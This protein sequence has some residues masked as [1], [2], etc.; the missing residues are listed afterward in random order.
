MGVG[1]SCYVL[2]CAKSDFRLVGAFFG[3]GIM[4]ARRKME[5][6]KIEYLPITDIEPYEGNA[7]K[8]PEKQ[9]NQ[10]VDSIRRFGFADPIAVWGEDNTIVE[11]HGRLYAAMKMGY[12]EVP[13]IRLDELTDEQRKAYGLIHNKLTMNSGFDKDKLEIELN[14]IENIDMQKFDFKIKEDLEIEQEDLS[15][16]FEE[17]FVME[18]TCESDESRQE[19]CDALNKRGFVCQ[20]K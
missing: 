9:I 13:V 11:G 5:K 2:G 16:L 18:V 17:G 6:L 7:K 8:H 3:Y 4:A 12:D 20:I 14:Q 19:L 15:G 10:I 1:L